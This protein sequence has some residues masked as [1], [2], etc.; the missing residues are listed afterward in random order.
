M[1]AEVVA[2]LVSQ[3]AQWGYVWQCSPMVGAI[4]EASAIRQLCR[5]T[6]EVKL[7][8]VAETVARAREDGQSVVSWYSDAGAYTDEISRELARSK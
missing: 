8:A 2:T 1:R 3:A 7:L 4:A 6:A 5:R